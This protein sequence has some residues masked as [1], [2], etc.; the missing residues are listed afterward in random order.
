MNEV[1]QDRTARAAASSRFVFLGMA[2]GA[3]VG[4]IGFQ[5]ADS[6]ALRWLSIADVALGV[7]AFKIFWRR[8]QRAVAKDRL[9]VL[10]TLLEQHRFA[11]AHA[12]QLPDTPAFYATVLRDIFGDSHERQ[13]AVLREVVGLAREQGNSALSTE[14]VGFVTRELKLAV[15]TDIHAD[16]AS[17]RFG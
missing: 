12:V 7:W 5:F 9:D 2:C 10:K 13:V 4:A 3:A 1:T 16:L 11:I 8:Q 17:G 15:P 14:I 6:P